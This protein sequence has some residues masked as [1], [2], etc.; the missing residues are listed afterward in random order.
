[1]KTIDEINEKIK[2]GKAVI[3]NAEEIIDLV[4]EK[5]VKKNRLPD[6]LCDRR[7]PWE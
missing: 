2:A 1:M 4:K 7:R 5:G 6:P 3:V